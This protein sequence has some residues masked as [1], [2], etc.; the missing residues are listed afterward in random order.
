MKGRNKLEAVFIIFVIVAFTY[1][2]VLT[3][4]TKPSNVGVLQTN[5]VYIE[6]VDWD[7]VLVV[8]GPWDSYFIPNAEFNTSDVLLDRAWSVLVI[9]RSIILLSTHRHISITKIQPFIGVFIVVV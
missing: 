3:V 7:P 6:I 1:G 4:T 5:V 8:N 2:V 9:T